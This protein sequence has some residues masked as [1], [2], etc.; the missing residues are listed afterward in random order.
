MCLY[1]LGT[2]LWCPLWFQNENDVRFVYLQLSLD[3]MSYCASVYIW[4]LWCPTFCLVICL[5]VLGFVLWCPPGFPH[6]TMFGSSLPPVVCGRLL[7][8]IILSFR[9]SFLSFYIYLLLIWLF[10]FI[11]IFLCC[12]LCTHSRKKYMSLQKHVLSSEICDFDK[13]VKELLPLIFT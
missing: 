12:Q 3:L 5:C 1:F 9:K 7:D 8:R 4:A 13:A 2:V 11:F 6:E 10:M